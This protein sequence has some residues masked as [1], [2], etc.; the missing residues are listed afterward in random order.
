MKQWWHSIRQA[1]K[2]DTNVRATSGVKVSTAADSMTAATNN[3]KGALTPQ[4]KQ[5]A[6]RSEAMLE[7]TAPSDE[8]S[9]VNTHVNDSQVKGCEKEQRSN[10]VTDNNNGSRHVS[11]D[12]DVGI[13]GGRR[14]SGLRTAMMKDFQ[15]E[16]GAKSANAVSC[17]PTQLHYYHHKLAH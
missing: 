16:F 7:T 4:P 5:P 11:F 14:V 17:V 9:H 15:N 2:R 10:N 1:K 12:N 3:A 8:A 13:A 6:K